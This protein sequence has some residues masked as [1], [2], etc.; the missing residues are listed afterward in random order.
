MNREAAAPEQTDGQGTAVALHKL[1]V[2]VAQRLLVQETSVE[3]EAGKV[4]LIVGRSGVGKSTLLRVIAKLIDEQEGAFR[5]AGNVEFRGSDDGRRKRSGVGVV[6]QDFALFD[7]LSPLQNV[8][9]ACS[10]RPR[11]HKQDESLSPKRLL[12]ELGVP[13]NVRTASLSGGERQRLAIARVLA[14][15]PD[16]MLYDEPTSGLDSATASEVTKL[17]GSTHTN[18]PRTSIIVTHDFEALTKIADAV[19]LIDPDTHALERVDRADWPRLGELLGGKVETAAD[20]ESSTE[21][22]RAPGFVRRLVDHTGDFMVTTTRVLETCV[23]LPIRLLPLWKSP[24]WGIRFFL[25][26]LRAVAG[27]SAWIYVAIAGAIIGF[28]AT[29]FTFRFLPNANYTKPLI[30]IENT[31]P[32]ATVPTLGQLTLSQPARKSAAP[33]NSNTRHAVVLTG[34]PN[35]ENPYSRTVST[36]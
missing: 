27:P 5:I 21:S 8:R 34:I 16:V 23:Q 19:Y 35:P 11:H 13:T 25:H 4:T 14:Y 30:A 2:R 12:N 17:I 15:D 20:D 26:Y 28:V 1:S 6:F 29:Y 7:E 3:F 36:K 10:H 22:K 32:E 33:T 31:I 9:L 18:H 24:W